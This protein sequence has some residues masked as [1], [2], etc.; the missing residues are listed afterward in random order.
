M[1]GYLISCKNSEKIIWNNTKYSNILKIINDSKIDRGEWK[2][3]KWENNKPIY[4][5]NMNLVLRFQK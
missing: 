3:I 2:K 1:G 5:K 4:D